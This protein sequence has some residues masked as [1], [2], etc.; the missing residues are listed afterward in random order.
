M[1]LCQ[2]IHYNHVLSYF[3][4]T[5]KITK[6]KQNRLQFLF[7]VNATALKQQTSQ[8]Y[9]QLLSTE[10]RFYIYDRSLT[11]INVTANICT[12]APKMRNTALCPLSVADQRQLFLRKTMRST[13]LILIKLLLLLH[14]FNGLFSRTTWVS[15]HQKCKPFW[16]L[17]QQEM[18]GWQWHQLD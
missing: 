11:D 7:A 14:P 3:N 15:W 2:P 10:A 17:R 13:N 18:M 16:I 6:K 4:K 12:V 9:A 1:L 5:T 8:F